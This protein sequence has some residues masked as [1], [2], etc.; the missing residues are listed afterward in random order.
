V[1]GLNRQVEK[2]DGQPDQQTRNDNP[3]RDSTKEQMSK[4]T[5]EEWTVPSHRR[6]E[7][8]GALAKEAPAPVN[9]KATWHRGNHPKTTT[10]SATQHYPII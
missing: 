9:C 10:G 6:G 5:K 4:D 1:G 7:H 2:Q 8:S 3:D